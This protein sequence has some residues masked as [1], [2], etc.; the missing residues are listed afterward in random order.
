[1]EYI[2]LHISGKQKVFYLNR[3]YDVDFISNVQPNSYLA[4]QRVLLYRSGDNVQIGTPF[5]KGAKIV[6]KVLQHIKSKK[7]FILKTKPK[8]HYTR[9]KGHKQYYTRIQF[10]K[11]YGT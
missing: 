9:L 1:M 3:W 5:L 7:L 4:L 11:E 6:V 2:I 8:K 10:L